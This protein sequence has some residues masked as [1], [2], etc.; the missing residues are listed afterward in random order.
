MADKLI[1][2]KAQSFPAYSRKGY[3]S[4]DFKPENVLD[5]L[6]QKAQNYISQKAASDKAFFL[7]FPLTSPH[8]PTLPAPR[9]RG[10]SGLG[11]YGD[12]IIQTDWV[13]G[14]IM[15]TLKKH[16]IDQNTLVIYSSDN[17]SYM[18]KIDSPDSPLVLVEDD[19]VTNPTVQGFFS[20]NHTAN[21]VYRGTK[22]DIYESGHRVPFIVHWPA[23]INAG[24][25]TKTISVTDILATCADLLNTRIPGN[26]A[27]D[28][29]SFLKVLQEDEINFSRPPV[30]T[31]SARGIFSIRI[32]NWK[33]IAGN[34]SGGRGLPK[35]KVFEK[36]Y[37]LYDLSNDLSEQNNLI[38]QKP[39][40]A[41]QMETQL[42][43]IIES[44]NNYSM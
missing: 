36:P 25:T 10:Q 26:A 12:F 8:K 28:S 1:E 7:Y 9:F 23:G 17:G 13:V 19:H 33:L 39:E 14:Q 42:L 16:K 15:N 3:A 27:E 31:H 32:K 37:Q 20:K 30:I 22:A 5:Q 44:S 6:T 40:L 11:N 43:K 18:Y 35:G 4:V 24:L 34:G 38:E 2:V 29:F 21:A 41:A